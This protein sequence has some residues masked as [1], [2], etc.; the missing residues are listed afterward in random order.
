MHRGSSGDHLREIRGATLSPETRTACLA[1]TTHGL[2]R[3]RAPPRIRAARMRAFCIAVGRRGRRPCPPEHHAR[4]F[5]TLGQGDSAS[6]LH[7]VEFYK[8][9]LVLFAP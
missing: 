3:R 2:P 8:V 1:A 9:D 4:H 6:D 5:V 7:K